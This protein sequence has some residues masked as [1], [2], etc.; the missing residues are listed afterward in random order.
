M[1]VI[2]VDG[3][4]LR[5]IAGLNPSGRRLFERS[6]GGSRLQLARQLFARRDRIEQRL[7]LHAQACVVSRLQK[8]GQQL[9][10][11]LEILLS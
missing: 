1:Y 4:G 5:R 9:A 10:R 11:G 2:N 8:R 6:G 3:T 7:S